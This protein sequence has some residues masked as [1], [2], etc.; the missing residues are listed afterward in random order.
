MAGKKDKN[1]PKAT[2]ANAETTQTG[3]S[4][5]LG[6]VKQKQKAEL[7]EPVE[8][9]YEKDGAEATG[10]FQL[11]VPTLYYQ[12]NIVTAEQAAENPEIM[13]FLVEETIVKG[14]SAFV[15]EIF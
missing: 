14:Q 2:E 1:T 5:S 9:T 3:N 8:V 6:T 12:G 13:K 15:S 7:P 11:K 4:L 10:K